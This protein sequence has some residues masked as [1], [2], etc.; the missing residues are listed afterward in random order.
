VTSSEVNVIGVSSRNA[1]HS[2]REKYDSDRFSS[3]R[4]SIIAVN[5]VDARPFP[6]ALFAL[7]AFPA[8]LRLSPV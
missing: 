4:C 2:A 6:R 8:L 5:R 7:C 1:A 3:V